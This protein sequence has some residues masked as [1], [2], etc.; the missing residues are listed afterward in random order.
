MIQ[1]VKKV[2]APIDFSDY[3][4]NALKGAWELAQEVGAELHLV[5]VVAPFF[6]IIEKSREL[7]R[8]TAMVE[9]AEQELARIKKDELADSPKVVTAVMVGPPVT[10][11]AEYA[12]QNKIDLVLLATHGRTGGEHLL[13][14]SVAEKLVRNA[15][16]SVLVLRPLDRQPAG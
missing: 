13:I 7:A 1:N 11:L 10:A 4:M 15:P 12:K 5:H 2:L 16:C 9:Q 3:S 8:E 6:T 14:G